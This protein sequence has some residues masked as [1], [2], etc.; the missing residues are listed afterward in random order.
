MAR[1]PFRFS[2]SKQVSPTRAISRRRF[3]V[4]RA[5]HPKTGSE[6]ATSDLGL[7]RAARCPAAEKK[8]SVNFAVSIQVPTTS[9]SSARMR[10]HRTCR[11]ADF[12][13][14]ATNEIIR[15]V[16]W[17]VSANLHVNFERTQVVNYAQWK[18]AARRPRP[19]AKTIGSRAKRKLFRTRSGNRGSLCDLIH[20]GCFEVTT[21]RCAA[22]NSS[23]RLKR[24]IRK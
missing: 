17:F 21:V 12:L 18:I 19:R 5:Q 7:N 1:N 11:G 4:P 14:R 3:A 23:R 6:V 24:C 22:E 20:A 2:R 8:F 16:P 9:P 10:S 13:V 15:Y